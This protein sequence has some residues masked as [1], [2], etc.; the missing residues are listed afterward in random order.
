MRE[1]SGGKPTGR[2]NPIDAEKEGIKD[3]DKV[4]VYNHR[5]HVTIEMRL[6]QVI[7][8][9]TVQVWFGWRQ[10]AFEDGMYSELIILEL[11]AWEKSKDYLR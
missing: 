5:G 8:P 1:L 10:E 7:P 11:P 2:M 4:E 3:G 6:D 9:G